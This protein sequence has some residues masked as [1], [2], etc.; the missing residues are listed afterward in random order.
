MQRSNTKLFIVLAIFACFV[1]G[2]AIAFFA[3]KSRSTSGPDRGLPAVF[4]PNAPAAT[5]TLPTAAKP[6]VYF[7]NWSWQSEQSNLT[8]WN[9]YLDLLKSWGVT[10][11]TTDVGWSRIE[12]KEGAF[13]FTRYD[14]R[15]KAVV[16]RGMDVI[17][18]MD[19]GVERTPDYKAQPAWVLKKYPDAQVEDFYHG[20]HGRLSLEH[21]KALAAYT[22]FV[23]TSL[24]HF[25]NKFGD[26]IRAAG[27]NFNNQIEMRYM[28]FE[29][30]W[31]DYSSSAQAGFRQWLQGK[32]GSIGRLNDAWGQGFGG[33]GEVTM[34]VI[35]KNQVG[36]DP[37]LRSNYID[38]MQFRQNSLV[39]AA[40]SVLDVI[41]A[42]GVKTYL[43]FGEVLTK[44]DAIFTLPM[45]DLGPSV[46]YLAIDY[47]HITGD[48]Q[49]TDPSLVGFI[50]SYAAQ[51]GAQAIFEDSVESLAEQSRFAKDRDARVEE[52]ITWAMSNGA[53][54]IGIANF[55]SEWDS[56]GVFKFQRTITK[57]MEKRRPFTAKAVAVYGSIWLPFGYHGSQDYRTGSGF[58]DV[59]QN[60][61]HGMFKLLEDA[62]IPVA[63]VS[64]EAIAQGVLKNY[65]VLIAPYQV[66]V[67]E[68]TL[69]SVRDWNAGGGKLVQD[70]RF[71][72][73][74]LTG[75]RDDAKLAD[76]FGVKFGSV[77]TD[78]A[79]VATGSLKQAL[80]TSDVTV[81]DVALETNLSNGLFTT[82][83]VSPKAGTETFIKRASGSGAA[84]AI[85][86]NKGTAFIGFEPGLL[87][88]TET[89]KAAKTEFQKL[90]RFVVEQLRGT[91]SGQ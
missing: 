18:I 1:A 19:T 79:A 47:N 27:P 34:P 91:V 46:D 16:D 90:I 75:G 37:D 64:D 69:K 80:G 14:D 88:L 40:T 26:G 82:Q 12:P 23:K 36:F 15:I 39:R 35:D 49:P 58:R 38:V 60:N 73:F 71:A 72:E 61:V 87:Y 89:D 30:K 8:S 53:S 44:D 86:K 65:D 9:S 63:V 51:Y 31:T 13:D 32:Y 74:S 67:P 24:T 59:F 52:A 81:G 56:Q 68:E 21:K 77:G 5:P 2:G 57:T 66:V 42:A 28:Q 22:T 48:G 25:K 85:N 3:F 7:A 62:G 11:I 41:K 4:A 6:F 33:F 50:T 10:T 43:H 45:Q 29:F 20:K 83:W 17:L 78:L 76:S 54:G 70:V 84:L 55:L